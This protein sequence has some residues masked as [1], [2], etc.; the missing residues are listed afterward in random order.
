MDDGDFL[1]LG[2]DDG[3][4]EDVV[5]M[6]KEGLGFWWVSGWGILF[7]F[8]VICCCLVWVVVF[9]WLWEICGG[10]LYFGGFNVFCNNVIYIV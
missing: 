4:D 7:W 8:V 10:L 5:V 3:I 1:D 2:V 6:L 9:V